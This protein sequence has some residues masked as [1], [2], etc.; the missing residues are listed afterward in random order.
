MKIFILLFFILIG[1]LGLMGWIR[2][3]ERKYLK[4]PTREAVKPQLREAWEGEKKDALRRKESFE[5]ML[6]RHGF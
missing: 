1:F 3:R 6:K 5:K 4:K 2:W